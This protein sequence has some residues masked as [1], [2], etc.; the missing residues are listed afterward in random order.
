MNVWP[1]AL[2]MVLRHEG[3]F[4]D[5]HSDP[6]SATYAG[7]SLRAVNAL[8]ADGDGELD[9]DLDGDGDVDRADIKALAHEPEKV[10]AF[11][12]ANYWNPIRGNQLPPRI[13]LLVFDAAVHHGV[14]GSTV[15]LQ[16]VLGVKQDGVLGPVTVE[17]A[18][19]A[20]DAAARLLTERALLMTRIVAARPASSVF[21]AGWFRRLFA[22]ASEVGAMRASA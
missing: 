8:D 13:A 3:G 22:L 2:E 7:V 5:H 12:L 4:A 9:F 1:L 15:L 18:W 17:A 19:R 11:Y 20:R 14:K 21:L 6:G 16:R 10:A